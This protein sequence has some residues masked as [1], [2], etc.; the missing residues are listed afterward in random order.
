[1]SITSV[2]I[3]SAAAGTDYA[4]YA[5]IVV[6]GVTDRY[7]FT[8]T[9]RQVDPATI[10][11]IAEESGKLALAFD[12]DIASFWLNGDTIQLSGL[13]G[14][15]AQF[16]GLHAIEEAPLDPDADKMLLSTPYTGSLVSS[17]TGTATRMNESLQV[18]IT[19]KDADTD[20]PFGTVD[21]RV[22][23]G[24][25]FSADI[26]GIVRTSFSSIFTLT[27][28][29]I[30]TTNAVKEI[31]IEIE[32]VFQNADYTTRVVNPAF[33]PISFFAHNTTDLTDMIT[34]TGLQ[35][36]QQQTTLR[37]GTKIIY[38][39]IV[40]DTV[41]PNRLSFT[42][43]IGSATVIS[44][45]TITDGH[46]GYVYEVASGV[47]SVT[48]R[49]YM[50]DDNSNRKTPMTYT[51]PTNCTGK[52]LYWL[53]QLGGYSVMVVHRYEDA[54]VTD[55]IDRYTTDSWIERTL[56]GIEEPEELGEYLKDLIDSPEIRDEN[57]DLVYVLDA[58]LIYRAET[59]QPVVTL[60]IEKEWLR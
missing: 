58:E 54:K 46:I 51:I 10:T 36:C 19:I 29:A 43:N 5:A 60:K 16:N 26:S 53:N 24:G 48:V 13:T 42:P 23:T 28:G 38:H 33:T 55:K 34:G 18:R 8:G 6:S 47:K 9:V 27:A 12:D 32:E 2:Q 20:D 35:N 49:L 44:N 45:P 11:A 37:A 14:D 52:L 56:Y 17:L 21:A 4:G 59:V 57:G 50:S 25:A 7:P 15:A 40:D 39:A 3:N 30:A 41:A 1:M 22:S 31:E